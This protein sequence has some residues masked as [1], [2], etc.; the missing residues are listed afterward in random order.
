[1]KRLA[2][3]AWLLHALLAQAVPLDHP[4]DTRRPTPADGLAAARPV[5][6]CKLARHH[7]MDLLAAPVGPDTVVLS[8]RLRGKSQPAFSDAPSRP[9]VAGKLALR[10][11]LDGVLVYALQ[12]DGG[13][14]GAVLRRHPDTHKVQRLEFSDTALPYG[15]YVNGDEMRLVVPTTG[16]NHASHYMIYSSRTGQGRPSNMLPSASKFTFYALQ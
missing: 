10:L 3:A 5:L 9:P 4:P 8:T 11:C 12:H 6:S 14:R 15:L 16:A 1:M 2:L 7:K 13:I